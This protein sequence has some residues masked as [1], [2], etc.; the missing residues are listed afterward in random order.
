MARKSALNYLFCNLLGL[1]LTVLL[2]ITEVEGKGGGR[3]PKTT[4][5]AKASPSSS[6]PS[7]SGSKKPKTKK[8]KDKNSKITRCY[9]E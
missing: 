7:I 9:H 1:V 6:G 3:N 2:A 8:I 4:T 5:F